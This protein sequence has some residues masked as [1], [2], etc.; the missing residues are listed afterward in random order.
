MKTFAAMA[1]FL[2]PL[3]TIAADVARVEFGA[4]G[5]LRVGMT[6]Q[7]AASATGSKL[8]HTDPPEVE[9]KSC[10]YGTFSYLPQGVSLMFIDG[11]LARIDVFKSGVLTRSG[12]QVGMP[13]Q[14]LNQLYGPQLRQ[15]PHFY[16]G[17]EGRYFTLLS[18][19][20]TQGIRFET[21]GARVTGFYTGTAAAIQYVEGCL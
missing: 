4:F 18:S 19:D 15:E 20:G 7:Q 2:A 12:A 14:K 6:E 13:E 21:D 8:V 5:V 11:H 17:P 16:T 10:F 3:V 1:L 9:E